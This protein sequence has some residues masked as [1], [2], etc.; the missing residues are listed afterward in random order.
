MIKSTKNM[1]ETT[2]LKYV[3]ICRDCGSSYC[4]AEFTDPKEAVQDLM[5][6]QGADAEDIDVYIVTHAFSVE[7]ESDFKL[8]P[9]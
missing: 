6:E 7:P 3:A 8:K 2:K 5:D 4:S 9:V 1:P